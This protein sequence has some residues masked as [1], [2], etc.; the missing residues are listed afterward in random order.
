MTPT[1][2]EA[3]QRVAWAEGSERLRLRFDRLWRRFRRLPGPVQ[4]IGWVF[5]GYWL[6]ELAVFRTRA[7]YRS[8]WRWV[9]FVCFVPAGPLMALM[10]ELPRSVGLPLA[11]FAMWPILAVAVLAGLGWMVMGVLAA[12]VPIVLEAIAVGAQGEEIESKV[13]GARL[14]GG[15]RA[16]LGGLA[17]ALL[18]LA[19]YASVRLLVDA[20]VQD[21]A[22]P[23]TSL[24]TFL[25]A[26]VGWTL[27]PI[28]GFTI[29][30]WTVVTMHRR[31]EDSP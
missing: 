18:G 7:P 1:T 12:K 28:V 4:A 30:A 17:G 20:L 3:A 23:G 13:R 19:A 9:F 29:G 10:V 26:A 5:L 25:D 27:F 6:A 14:R 8:A 11:L 24:T 21:P 2:G 31:A 15:I 22:G 16:V